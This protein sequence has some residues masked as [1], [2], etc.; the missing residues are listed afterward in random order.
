MKQFFHKIMA[1]TMALVVLFSTLSF[2]VGMHYCGD[3]LVDTS[4]F[5]TAETC[6]MEMEKTVTTS[7]CSNTKKNCCSDE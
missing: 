3:V 7:E 4:M 1:S 5:H 2:T 6:G